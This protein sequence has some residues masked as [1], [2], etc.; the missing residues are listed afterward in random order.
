MCIKPDYRVGREEREGDSSLYQCV[1]LFFYLPLRLVTL[2][3]GC[4]SEQGSHYLALNLFYAS[5]RLYLSCTSMIVGFRLRL[6]D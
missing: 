3:T 4:I 2:M 6:Y 1:A 5:V